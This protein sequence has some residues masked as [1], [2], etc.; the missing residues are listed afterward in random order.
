MGNEYNADGKIILR[1]TSGNQMSLPRFFQLA[2][3]D[4]NGN[5]LSVGVSRR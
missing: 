2:L 3:V 5:Y 4:D 1:D